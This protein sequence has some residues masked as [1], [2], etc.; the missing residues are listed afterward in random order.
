MYAHPGSYLGRSGLAT[1]GA[2][3][4][5]ECGK[6]IW[7]LNWM[8]PWSWLSKLRFNVS[9][10]GAVT[11]GGSSMSGPSGYKSEGPCMDSP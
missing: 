4:I 1:A 2:Q 3:Y 9:R 5:R 8:T 10:P 7:E 6:L 11:F